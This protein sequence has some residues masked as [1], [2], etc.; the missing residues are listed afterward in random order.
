M[1]LYDVTMCAE[2]FLLDFNGQPNQVLVPSKTNTVRRKVSLSRRIKPKGAN[3]FSCF[4][5]IE[6]VLP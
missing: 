2:I 3:F 1:A 6:L 4:V 5:E